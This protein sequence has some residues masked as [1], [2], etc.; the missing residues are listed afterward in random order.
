M[1]DLSI[2]VIIPVYNAERS[3]K[4]TIDS[5]LEQSLEVLEIIVVDDGSTDNTKRVLGGYDSKVRYIYQKNAGASVARNTGIDN[6]KGSWIAFIDADDLWVS[7]KLAEQIDLIRLYPDAGMIFSSYQLRG[8]GGGVKYF[9]DIHLFGKKLKETGSGLVDGCF[10]FLFKDNFIKT[11]TLVVRKDILLFLKGFDRKLKTVED[12]DLC[13][14]IANQSSVLFCAKDLVAKNDHDNSLGQERL[15]VIND[16]EFVQTTNLARFLD[17]IKKS[18]KLS[19]IQESIMD[20][21]YARC[22]Y[23]FKHNEYLTFVIA[24]SDFLIFKLFR[25]NL[26]IFTRETSI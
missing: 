19:L 10:Y 7:T 22:R 20:T 2:S 24:I 11:S 8:S 21:K 3:I 5:V 15:C 23:C 6:A 12:R 9:E 16:R 17:K 1:F 18:N 13:I 4:R 14:R 25:I 26:R